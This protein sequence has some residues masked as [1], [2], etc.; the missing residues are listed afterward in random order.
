[1][2]NFGGVIYW[3]ACSPQFDEYFSCRYLLVAK[4]FIFPGFLRLGMALCQFESLF[5]VTREFAP[6]TKRKNVTSMKYADTFGLSNSK[7]HWDEGTATCKL[8]NFLQ[9]K[10][11]RKHVNV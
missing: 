2:L 7:S 1:M 10:D 5:L 3:T 6:S 9:A 8:V 4:S 11:K